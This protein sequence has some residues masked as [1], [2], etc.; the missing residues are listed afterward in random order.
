MSGFRMK[1]FLTT[2]F[3]IANSKPPDNSLA[4]EKKGL[5][6]LLGCC[7]VGNNSIKDARIDLQDSWRVKSKVE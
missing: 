7:K 3:K 4:W 5:E 6:R 1:C 2:R